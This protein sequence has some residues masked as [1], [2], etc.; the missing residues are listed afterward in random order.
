[1]NEIQTK[2]TLLRETLALHDLDAAY[3]TRIA[4]FGWLTGG[5][6]GYVGTAT[7]FGA[8]GLLVTPDAQYVLTT[9]IEATRLAAEEVLEPYNFVLRP[10]PWYASGNAVAELAA[11]LRLGADAPY[12]GAQ[13]VA[14]M[15][16]QLRVNLLPEEGERY[17]ELG[18]LCAA[19]MDAAVRSVR[20]GMTEHE[21][22][23]RT[24]AETVARGPVPIVN[25]VATDERIFRFRHPLPTGKRMERYAMLVLGA[26]LYGLVCSITR[27][28][29]FGPL[30]DEVRQKMEACALVDATYLAYT[31]PGRHISEVFAQGVQ[32]YADTGFPDEWQLH[33][34]GGMTGYLPREY[35]G[36]PGVQ[37]LVKQG[38][39]YAWNPS[40]TGVKSEDTI[41]VGEQANEVITEIPGW[42][43]VEVT[44]GGQAYRRPAILE[45]G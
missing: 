20:P 44:V 41:L 9:N 26:R 39:A 16:R 27:L 40:I 2:L 43:V 38:Q 29:H 33:H 30:P 32:A 17:R 19:A 22:A 13:D 6:S 15:M 8:A 5:A 23:A 25:L 34:Q 4:N 21:I 14:E 45:A 36:T 37:Q 7:D 18:S 24:A 3:L 28:V 42:P 12:P 1:M 31:R 35:V 11:G 10:S